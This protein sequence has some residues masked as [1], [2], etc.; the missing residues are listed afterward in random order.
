MIVNVK[1]AIQF[2]LKMKYTRLTREQLEEF[3]KG[4]H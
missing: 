2:N 4:I 1:R 3:T